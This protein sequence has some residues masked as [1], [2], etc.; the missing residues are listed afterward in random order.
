MNRF[1]IASFFGIYFN[2]EEMTFLTNFI[3]K[4]ALYNACF[5]LW[6]VIIAFYCINFSYVFHF[7]Y[8]TKE[9]QK[10]THWI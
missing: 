4:I 9:R 6:F 5:I 1:I 10:N 7:Y 2:Q 3:F 8:T